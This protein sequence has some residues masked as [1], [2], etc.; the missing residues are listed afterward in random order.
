MSPLY[1]IKFCRIEMEQR[2]CKSKNQQ[3]YNSF[4]V[5]WHSPMFLF[6]ATKSWIHK[7]NTKLK[8]GEI[9]KS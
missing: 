5:I 2:F 7:P 6:L 4:T 8:L 9:L 3:K 1:E